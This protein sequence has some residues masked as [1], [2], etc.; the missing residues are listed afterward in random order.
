MALSILPI[1]SNIL[2]ACSMSAEDKYPTL[3]H[4]KSCVSNS[5]LEPCAMEIK[6]VYSETEWRVCPSAILE[7]ID[8]AHLRY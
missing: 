7:G 3:T 2:I 4:S 8:T 6:W 1:S 5:A